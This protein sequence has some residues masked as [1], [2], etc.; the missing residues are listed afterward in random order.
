[1]STQDNKNWHTDVEPKLLWPSILAI[2]AT[3][4]PLTLY[5]EAGKKVVSDLLSLYTGHFGWLYLLTGIGSFFFML[6]LAFS[7][8][9]RIKLGAPED[10]PEFSNTAWIAMLFCAGIGISIVNW[11]FVE[12]LYFLSGPPL[13]ISP[14]STAAAEWAAMY[15]LFHWGVVPWALYLVPALPI[16]YVLYV[17]RG[18]L[19]R[20]SEACR[21]ILGDRVD[22][23]LGKLIDIIVIFSIIGGVGTSLGLSIPLGTQLLGEEFGLPDSFAMQMMVLAAWT[24]LFGWSAYKGLNKGIQVLSNINAGLALILLVFVLVVGPTVFLLNLGTNSF[25]LMLDNFFRVNFWTDPVAK[26]GLPESWTIFYW[27]WW[28]AYCPMMGLFVARISRGRTIKNI[29]LN[30]VLWG[31]VGC[32]SFFMIWGGYAVHLQLEGIVPVVQILNQQGIP[33]AVLAILQT[34][35]LYDLVL[36]VFIMLCFVFLAT[37]VDSS[38]YMLAAICARQLSGYEEPSR[39]SRLLWAFALALVGVGLL[40]V[41]GLQAVQTSTVLVALPMIP[42]LVIMVLSLLR[43]ARKDYG[44]V[45]D[46]KMYALDPA[47]GKVV[48]QK[49]QAK[50]AIPGPITGAKPKPQPSFSP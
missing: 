28:I 4:I 36:P 17:R 46:A 34:L 43:W 39:W 49:P 15:P 25:G 18:N 40:S 33:A 10:T 35:P 31:S 5:P 16:G 2:L 12:P 3:S 13:G 1:M 44:E 27:A 50:Q 19:L 42:V 47:S 21:G 11:S 26:G 30:G 20:L 23:P 41:G 14:G 38:A 9:G 6:W 37:T 32:W 29:I 24:S 22:G 45:L 48:E 8:F 7:R